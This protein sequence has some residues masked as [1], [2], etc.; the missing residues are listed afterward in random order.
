MALTL[1]TVTLPD[2]LYWQD[3]FAWNKKTHS[4]AYGITGSLF[5]QVGTKETGRDITLVGTESMG[6]VTRDVVED[7]QTLRDTDPE[8]TLTLPD[9]RTFTVM[10][11]QD[12]ECID[13]E[14]VIPHNQ[15]EATGYYKINAIR[16][17]QV[18]DP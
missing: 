5:V 17:F 11:K 7:L 14:P 4:K 15:Y 8:M 13:V 16:L 2:E 18:P 10:F 6:W 3:E 9:S 12:E 1:D